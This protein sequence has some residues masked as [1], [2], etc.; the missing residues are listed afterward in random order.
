M[1]AP[2]D[3]LRGTGPLPSEPVLTAGAIGSV[4]TS[5]IAVMVAFAFPLTDDQQVAILGLVTVLAPLVM[6]VIHRRTVYAPE[7]VRL[8]LETERDRP[9]P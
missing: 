6:A 9:R 7:S 5:I 4:T 8:L 2:G 3:P 1:R